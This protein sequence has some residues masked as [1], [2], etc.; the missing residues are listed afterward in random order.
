[1]ENQMESTALCMTQ[2]RPRVAKE[3]GTRNM[4]ITVFCRVQV[5]WGGEGA[6]KIPFRFR[7]EMPELVL[8]INEGILWFRVSTPTSKI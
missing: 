6:L 5:S 2:G 1:M 8:G 7:H 3:E 4:E